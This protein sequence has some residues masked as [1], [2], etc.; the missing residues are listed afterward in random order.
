[1]CY[2]YHYAPESQSLRCH[3]RDWVVLFPRFASNGLV[4]SV[5]SFTGYVKNAMGCN[6]DPRNKIR[7]KHP[8]GSSSDRILFHVADLVLD[9]VFAIIL[10]F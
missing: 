10:L 7:N 6:S 3:P 9:H 1:M 2:D 8:M 4:E 5:F